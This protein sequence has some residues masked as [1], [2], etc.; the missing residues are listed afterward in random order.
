MNAKLKEYTDLILPNSIL[1]MILDPRFKLDMMASG[2]PSPKIKARKQFETLF[3]VYNK[4]SLDQ[5]ES[6]SQAPPLPPLNQNVAF[7]LKNSIS[8]FV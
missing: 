2:S 5:S 1:P 6:N 4:T 3:N 8:C 7:F